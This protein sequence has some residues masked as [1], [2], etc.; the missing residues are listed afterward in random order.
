MIKYDVFCDESR[1]LEHDIF[2]YMLI[3]GIWCEHE[4]RRKIN[5]VILEMKNNKCC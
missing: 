4:Y 1:H 5:A 3:G 2:Q